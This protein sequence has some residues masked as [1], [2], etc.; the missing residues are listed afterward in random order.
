HLMQRMPD[1]SLREFR[2]LAVEVGEVRAAQAGDFWLKDDLSRPARLGLWAQDRLGDFDELDAMFG[3]EM[4]G[5]Q[6]S[7]RLQCS[8]VSPKPAARLM[9]ADAA[10]MADRASLSSGLGE[11]RLHSRNK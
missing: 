1:L 10:A 4:A 7:A 3:G 6:K 5:K 11:T 9:A 8:R 2:V